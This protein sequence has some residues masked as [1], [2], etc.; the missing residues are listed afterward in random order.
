MQ[1]KKTILHVDIN[2]YFATL[3][4][5]ENPHLRGQPIGVVKNVGRTCI[6]AASKEAKLH[7]VKTGTTTGDAKQ[8]CPSIQFLAADFDRYLAATQALSALFH[9][10]CPTVYIY[11]LDEAFLDITDCQN[12]L[13][14]DPLVFAKLVQNKIKQ[15]LGEWVTCNVGISYN[16]L[17]AKLASEIAP[18]G[19]IK[20]I[21]QINR[22]STLATVN[23][24]DVCGVGFRLEHKLQALHVTHPYQIR[25]L[26]PTE[27]K[28]WVG[29][30]WQKELFKIAYG[31]ETHHFDL[32][33]ASGRH[34]GQTIPTCRERS[35]E[36][37]SGSAISLQDPIGDIGFH[38]LNSPTSNSQS[39]N[40]PVPSSQPPTNQMKTVSRSITTWQLVNDENTIHQILLNLSIEVTYKARQMHLT[41]RQIGIF[42]SG[43]RKA[44]SAHLTLKHPINH[45]SEYFHYLYHHLYISW[46]R[47]FSIIKFGVYLGLL[48]S[49]DF[50]PTPLL[51]SWHQQ[52]KLTQATDA[53]NH[54]Y[55]LF[56]LHPA[57]LLNTTIIRP[58]VTGFLGDKAFWGV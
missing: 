43:H 13:Y 23:F 1:I 34:A 14:P 3:L 16:F 56:T 29:S 12:Y 42:L 22:D 20:T 46:Q 36:L 31:E 4:Q 9:H 25:F 30:F 55:G 40:L 57:S 58:E 10:L 15:T 24:G 11:S 35:P 41:G 21:D 18:K 53:L 28:R 37:V 33:Q 44:W 5:Q 17:L 26:D 38:N 2:S 45:T 32:L 8:R 49:I 54:R 19:S 52:E 6:I 51:P 50:T 39:I 47:P 7:G 48:Q 27:L